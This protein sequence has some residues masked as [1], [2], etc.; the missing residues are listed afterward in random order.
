M[1]I[2]CVDSVSLRV[3]GR[4]SLEDKTENLESKYASQIWMIWASA[5]YI[6]VLMCRVAKY[7]FDCKPL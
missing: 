4:D 5:V 3:T 6:L 1:T 2:K 7:I